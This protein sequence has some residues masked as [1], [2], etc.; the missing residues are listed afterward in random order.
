MFQKPRG[1]NDIYLEAIDDFNYV[2]ERL[3]YIANLYNF[4]QIITPTFESL[5][6]F[7]KNIGEQTDIVH[8]EVY[9][10][11][12]KGDRWLA[13]RP[14]GTAGVVRSYVENKLY[15]NQNEVSKFWY[16]L[17]LFRYERPQKGRN[18]EFYQFGVEYLGSN[19][20]LDIIDCIVFAN[21]ILKLLGLKNY[22]LKINYLGDKETRDKWIDDLKQ[23]FSKFKDDLTKDSINRLDKN[24]LRILDDKIDGEK[25]FV[26]NAPK[27]TAHLDDQSLNDFKTIQN[28]LTSLGIQYQV[29]E[30]LVRGLDY[31]NNCVFEF[32]STND[33]LSKS[34][35]IGGG[36]YD[37]L[38]KNTGGPDLKGLGFAIGIERL[39]IALKAESLITLPNKNI[40]YLVASLNSEDD[41]L[42]FAI[43]TKLKNKGVNSDYIYTNK[44]QKINKYAY[45]INAKNIIWV[46]ENSN[47][48]NKILIEDL[49]S[50]EKK[51]LNINDI[52][53]LKGINNE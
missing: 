39:I 31:Y 9:S 5:D 14:E 13:L 43:S 25:D 51:E 15:A 50:N 7:I 49:A 48:S 4:H 22:E 23:Y 44:K 37:E 36:C 18:R 32:V 2:C 1:T 35:I 16:I 26:K 52:F 3:K 29:D 38:I 11:K 24:P 27:L 28:H 45:L 19:S 40:E 30:S 20:K 10:F 41:L 21:S 6:L 46:D 33:E 12:D 47:T 34:T 8:K 17:N 53:N 42:A